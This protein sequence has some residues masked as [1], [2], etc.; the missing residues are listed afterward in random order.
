M[1]FAPF[2]TFAVYAIIMVVR[3]DETLLLAQAF[4]IIIFDKLVDK[5]TASLL[6]AS[7]VILSSGFMFYSYR[8]V[9]LERTSGFTIP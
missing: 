2:L 7:A 6:S 8:G 1:T 3:K 9:L 4:C 5:P